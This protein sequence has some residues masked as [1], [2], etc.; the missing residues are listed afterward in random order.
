MDDG[1]PRRYTG[2]SVQASCDTPGPAT[3]AWL[4]RLGIGVSITCAVHCV[5]S[6]VLAAVPAI[7]AP[8]LGAQLEWAEGP[9]LWL[10]LAIGAS[11]LVPA[12]L[13]HRQAR[14]LAVFLAGA[15]M[16]GLA[17]ALGWGG[18]EIAGTIGGVGLVS[19]AHVL[20]LR[21][22]HAGHGH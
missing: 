22:H 2:R 20:N 18:V 17:H 8:A 21:A 10:A 19:T 7:A 4:D 1:G 6:G 15:A 3:R 12:Y 14:P 13:R 5:A 9:F 11:A 16:I